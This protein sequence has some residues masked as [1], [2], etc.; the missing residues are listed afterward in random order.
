MHQASI[1]TKQSGNIFLRDAG[2]LVN[3]AADRAQVLHSAHKLIK[4][5]QPPHGAQMNIE[6]ALAC[7]NLKPTFFCRSNTG[8]CSITVDGARRR[9]QSAR[10]FFASEKNN[11]QAFSAD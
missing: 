1:C 8:S 9:P 5:A 7:A 6:D 3:S 2:L 11:Q 4:V 10:R